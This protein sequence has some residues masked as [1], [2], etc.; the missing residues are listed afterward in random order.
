MSVAV[1]TPAIP[2]RL[3]SWLPDTIESV[4]SQTRPVDQHLIGIDYA[5]A[6]CAPTMNRLLAGAAT[7]WV[8]PL[9]DD[10]VLYPEFVE[11]CLAACDGY[12]VVAPWCDTIGERNDHHYIHNMRSF[13]PALLAEENYIPSTSLIRRELLVDVG[14]WPEEYCEDWAL[15]KVFAERGAR[16]LLL[17]QELWAYRLH[18][19]QKT[20]NR[21]P[22]WR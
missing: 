18:G 20:F 11:E 8:V 14:G 4:R 15:W 21:L 17:P 9:A 19:S 2:P 13:D 10:D 22:V 7:E 1:I 12:D 3:D 16:F 5:A 6:G